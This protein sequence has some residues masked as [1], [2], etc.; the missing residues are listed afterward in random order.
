M[1]FHHRNY[2]L[3]IMYKYAIIL[4]LKTP[5]SQLNYKRKPLNLLIQLKKKLSR[6]IGASVIVIFKKY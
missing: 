6:S 2:Y 4:L 1:S 5:Y 3:L